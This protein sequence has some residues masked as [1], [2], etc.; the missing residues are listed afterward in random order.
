MA[1]VAAAAVT[2]GTVALVNVVDSDE[3][4]TPAAA[5]PSSV[6]SAAPSQKAAKSIPM[7]PTRD[8]PVT[9]EVALTGGDWGTDVKLTCAWAAADE[10]GGE[11]KSWEYTLVVRTRDGGTEQVSSWEARPGRTYHLTGVTSTPKD[12]IV[13]VEVQNVEGETLLRAHV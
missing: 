2:A 10:P 12:D 9:A 4:S 13:S 6:A 8:L 5:E 1:A 7:Y 3:P 11:D